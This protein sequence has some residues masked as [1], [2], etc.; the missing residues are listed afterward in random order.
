M[1]ALRA[2]LA[3]DQHAP[4]ASARYEHPNQRGKLGKK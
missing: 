2:I 4:S 3:R 1:G